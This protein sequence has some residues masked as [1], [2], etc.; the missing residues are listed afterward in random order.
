MKNSPRQLMQPMENKQM[1]KFPKNLFK[2]KDFK[3]LQKI[4]EQNDAAANSELDYQ[5]GFWQR[6]MFDQQGKPH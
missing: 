2:S 4:A 6:H 3:L 1:P 5:P